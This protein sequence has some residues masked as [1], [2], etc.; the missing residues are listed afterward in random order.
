MVDK[1]FTDHSGAVVRCVCEVLEPVAG[2]LVSF[3][4]TL[5]SAGWAGPEVSRSTLRFLDPAGLAELVGGAG[6][7]VAEQFG[8]WDRRALTRDCREIITV[9]RHPRLRA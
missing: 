7:I 3:T 1:L 9:A 2:D 6:L 4:H 8:D 5:S